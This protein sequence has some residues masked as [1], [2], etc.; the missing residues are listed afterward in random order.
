MKQSKTI[1]LI[2]GLF[3][4][5][6]SWK[7]WRTY[8][9]NAGYTVHTPANPFHDGLPSELRAHPKQGLKTARLQDVI[10]NLVTLID[11]LPEKPIVI[12]H[13]LAGFVVQKLVEMNKAVA[14]ISI[15]G[16]PPKNVFPGIPTVLA[17][18]PVVNPFSGNSEFMGSR[19]WYHKHFFNSVSRSESDRLYD[20]FAVPESRRVARETLYAAIARVDHAKPHVPLLF[21]G[22]GA[23][24]IFPAAFTTRNAAAY[25]PAGGR[26]DLKIFEG[27]T[28]F[29]CGQQGWEEVA[30]YIAEWLK[31]L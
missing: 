4:T 6:H 27:R 24:T 14:G 1:V 10:A 25:K 5:N 31:T 9:E 28:H 3:V 2:H 22:G 26:T 18:A 20:E 23:D 12:G 7:A 29:I 19:N 17:V 30:G 13:S 15:N 8:F 11:S 16:A 21:I